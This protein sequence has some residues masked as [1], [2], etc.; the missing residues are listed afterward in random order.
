MKNL[1]KILFI[2]L[3][4]S[5]N[6]ITHKQILKNPDD[7]ELYP[8]FPLLWDGEYPVNEFVATIKLGQPIKGIDGN[9]I[10][11]LEKYEAYDDSTFILRLFLFNEN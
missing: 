2:F 7:Y 11:I 8:D 5:C 4:L 3:F 1:L 9:T 10:Y 6:I